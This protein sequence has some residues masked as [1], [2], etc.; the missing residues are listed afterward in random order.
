M[1]YK[2]EDVDC[3]LAF[4]GGMDATAVLQYLL[5]NGRK[6]YIFKHQHESNPAINRLVQ[7]AADAVMKYYDVKVVNWQASV[8]ANDKGWPDRA[9]TNAHYE[10][11]GL[12]PPSL[13]RWSTQAMFANYNMPWIS[14]IYWG[15]CYGGFLRRGDGGGDKLF[16]YVDGKLTRIAPYKGPMDKS[17]YDDR[18]RQLFNGYLEWLGHAKIERNYIAALGHYSKL[19]LYKMLPNNIKD[20]MVTCIKYGATKYT[21]QCGECHKC[22]D[23]I[24]IRRA[25]AEGL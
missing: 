10:K 2:Q 13:V 1:R 5:D 16:N 9:R 14:E 15:M 12:S 20:S 18:H 24:Q 19:E 17:N 23:L 8:I 6:P 11:A 4:S 25:Y 22:K 3:I 21:K 7:T